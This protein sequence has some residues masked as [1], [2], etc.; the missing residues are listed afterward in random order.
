MPRT[1]RGKSTSTKSTTS[2]KL[3]KSSLRAFNESFM[4]GADMILEHIDARLEKEIAQ[5]QIFFQGVKMQKSSCLNKTVEEM[6][7]TGFLSLSNLNSLSTTSNLAGAAIS[8]VKKSNGNQGR[9]SRL[10]NKSKDDEAGSRT[11]SLTRESKTKKTMTVKKNTRRSKSCSNNNGPVINY[12][13]PSNKPQN[14]GYITPKVKLNTPQALLRRPDMGEMAFSVQG[15]PLMTSDTQPKN[16]NINI[17]LKNGQVV[18]IQPFGMLNDSQVPELDSHMME[19]MN[20]LQKN[21]MKFIE[22]NMKK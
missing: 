17:P 12:T 16:A 20:T 7:A 5:I 18:S 13:T 6:I 8:T 1:K 11:S 9:S 22:K 21:L 15:S 14:F 19:Q 3:P 10:R 2:I 4:E